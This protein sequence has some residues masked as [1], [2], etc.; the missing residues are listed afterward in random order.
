MDARQKAAYPFQH[1]SVVEFGCAAAAPRAHAELEASKRMQGVAAQDQRPDGR[2][3]GA[4]SS[5][6]NACSSR[7]CAV[8]QR[9]GR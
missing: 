5:A 4:I 9:P 2:D 6:A 8:L 1:F 3:L 7:I